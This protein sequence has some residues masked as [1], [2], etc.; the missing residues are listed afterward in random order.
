M[1]HIFEINAAAGPAF[2]PGCIAFYC[3]FDAT[4]CC[5]PFGTEFARVASGDLNKVAINIRSEEPA[6]IAKNPFISYALEN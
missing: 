1:H 5:H 6:N 2:V 4:K 3:F